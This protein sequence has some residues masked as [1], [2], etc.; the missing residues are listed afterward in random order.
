MSTRANLTIKYYDNKWKFEM[1]SYPIPKDVVPQLLLMVDKCKN[2]HDLCLSML[3]E[4]FDD[5]SLGHIGNAD[6]FYEI[7]LVKKT[8]N[9]YESKM[10]WI[11]APSNWKERGW[12]GIYEGKNGRMGY[13]SIVK[14]KKIDITEYVFDY[15]L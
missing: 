11:N 1:N 6:Y 3:Q 7:D 9:A 15:N 8:I 10:T 14:G 5:M 4:A 2:Q 12:L 13:T